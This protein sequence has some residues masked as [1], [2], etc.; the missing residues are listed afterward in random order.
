MSKL[1]G[2][3]INRFEENH[4]Y[5]KDK[6]IHEGDDITMYYWSDRECYYVTRVIDQKHLFV[7]RYFVCADHSKEG[8]VGHQNW[9]Y[10]KT[11]REEAEYWNKCIDEGLVNYPGVEKEDLNCI[12]EPNEKEWVFRYGYWREVIRKDYLGRDLEKPKY[13]KL[14]PIS[15]GVRQYYYDWSF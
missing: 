1:Y 6:L 9:L 12:V 3:V 2:N 11:S 7:K 13:V 15:F 14:Q 4:N 5:N 8:G 10:F